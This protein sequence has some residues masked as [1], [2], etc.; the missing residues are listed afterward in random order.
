MYTLIKTYVKENYH[1]SQKDVG[2]RAINMLLS[3][4]QEVRC[5]LNWNGAASD[6][7]MDLKA[8]L[9]HLTPEDKGNTL[10]AFI[11]SREEEIF[12]YAKKARLMVESDAVTFKPTYDYGMKVDVGNHGYGEGQPIPYGEDVDLKLTSD[13]LPDYDSRH[14]S[15][16]K[17]NA[18][19]TIN[20]RVYNTHYEAGRLFVLNGHEAIKREA[21]YIVSVVDFSRVGGIVKEGIYKE[22]LKVV[23]KD[24][25]DKAKHQTRVVVSFNTDPCGKT[26]I[27]VVNGHFHI[28]DG[29]Y[30]IIDADKMLVTIDHK[31]AVKRAIRAPFNRLE[32]F[33]PANVRHNGLRTDRFYVDK[34]LDQ[35]E[36]FL[37]WVN[38]SELSLFKE[39]IKG[40]GIIG[41][42]NHYRAPT[43]LVFNHEHE[44]TPYRIT[45]YNQRVCEIRTLPN[46]YQPL[47]FET[48]EYGLRPSIS[49]GGVSTRDIELYDAFSLDLYVF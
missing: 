23:E 31:L 16:L 29:S 30:K 28:F 9:H 40:T 44:L 42:Y 18:L 26:P 21:R 33:D 15:K 39:H 32:W 47:I 12:D 20:G 27:L 46:T 24:D 5:R 45:D 4:Y 7:L 36:S 10:R 35:T 34:Y 13:H 11:E 48:V 37:V 17:D 38:T 1:W 14:V 6:Y 2:D 8:N 3:D 19:F 41:A 25:N 49:T 22:N 43:G